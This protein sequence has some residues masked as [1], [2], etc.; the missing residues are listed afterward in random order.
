MRQDRT[1]CTEQ[2]RLDLAARKAAR[3]LLDV[4]EDADLDDLKRAYRIAAVRHHPDHNGNTAEANRMFRLVQCAYELLAF[5]KSCSKLLVEMDSLADVPDD[6]TYRLDNPWGHF[7][8]WREKF[9]E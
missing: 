4:E 6:G 3:K 5:D 9:F 1:D 2:V 7:C 8:W